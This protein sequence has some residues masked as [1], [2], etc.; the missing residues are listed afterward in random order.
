MKKQKRMEAEVEAP[1]NHERWLLTY[2]D[3]ITLLVAFFIM[4]Y[5]M[6]VVNMAKFQQ[7]A[8]AIRSGFM[9]DFP[10]NSGKYIFVKGETLMGPKASGKPALFRAPGKS[11]KGVTPDEFSNVSSSFETESNG[12]N[13]T[14]SLQWTLLTTGL[15]FSP[16]AT[17]LTQASRDKL[18]ALRQ[19]LTFSSGMILVEGYT[20]TP[21][22]ETGEPEKEENNPWRL[23]SERAANVIQYLIKEF[24]IDRSRFMLKAYG[25]WV[26][27][28]EKPVHKEWHGSG[29]AEAGADPNTPSA[30]GTGND[31]AA[32][33]LQVEKARATH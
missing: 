22:A 7:F 2:A 21:T 9:G 4:M 32:V 20:S 25:D 10:G 11:D 1:E 23:S 33:L 6:S 15:V 16:G 30:R 26:S 28:P 24:G 8:V 27:N 5:S 13:G 12:A 3:L 18:Q 17:N 31:L 29:E 14:E 19:D